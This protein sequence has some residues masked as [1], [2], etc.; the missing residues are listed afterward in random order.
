MHIHPERNVHIHINTENN[1]IYIHIIL[2]TSECMQTHRKKYIHIYIMQKR[3][4]I[5]IN[6]DTRIHVHIHFNKRQ[7]CTPALM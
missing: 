6:I 4:H 1:A 2:K 5:H 3:M 7:K